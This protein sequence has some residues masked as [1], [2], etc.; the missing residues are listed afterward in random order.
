MP[1]AKTVALVLGSLILA[2]TACGG[3]GAGDGG[4]WIVGLLERIP[5][6][7]ESGDFVTVVDLAAAAAAAGIE[8]PGPGPSDDAV[9]AYL[10]GLP[11]DALI[12]D[13]LR[14][15][16]RDLGAL[17]TELGIDPAAVRAGIMAGRPPENYEVLAGA[18][19]STMV[20]QAVRAD[21]LWSDLLVTG[22]HGGVTYYSWGEDLRSYMDRVSAVRPI[23]R[24][25]RLALDGGYL[26]WV[27]W[28]AGI[29][30][31]ID[32]GAGIVPSLADDDGLAAVA[33]IL[34]REEVYSAILT[35]TALRKDAV[36][37]A[38]ALGVG[39]G[40]DEAGAY[41][42]VVAVHATP[43]DAEESAV[44][45]GRVLEE[46]MVVGL[47][48]PWSD[49]VAEYDIAVEGTT[50]VVVL[51]SNGAEGDWVRAVQVADGLILAAQE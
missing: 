22:E 6:T 51:R 24:S 46:G 42:V 13:L 20:D 21:P 25:G 23:G 12:P 17:T 39:G 50:L 41:W 49:R 47:S 37:A 38:S 40:R 43:E 34:E 19:D 26:Y 30:G 45:V 14:N 29:E 18:F 2:A 32:A 9:A 44:E 27:P 48:A 33:G 15:L 1:K 10:M 16:V 5:D 35:D 36:A 28:T 3:D 4:G 7:A 8:I 31:L 11:R